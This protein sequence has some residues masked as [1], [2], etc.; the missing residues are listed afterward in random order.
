MSEKK[1]TKDDKQID[2]TKDN[3]DDK[4]EETKVEE[5]KDKW[6]GKYKIKIKN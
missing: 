1:D 5:P 4:K 2:S 6:F 3:K